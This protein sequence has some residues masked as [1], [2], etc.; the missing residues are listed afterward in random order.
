MQ[1]QR[2]ALLA[3]LQPGRVKQHVPLVPMR[4]RYPVHARTKASSV[5]AACS[6]VREQPLGAAL[7][8]PPKILTQL[9][10]LYPQIQP[11]RRRPNHLRLL[12]PR[13]LPDNVIIV[14]EHG[15]VVV[16]P[17]EGVGLPHH[18]QGLLDGGR[19]D[20]EVVLGRKAAG[21]E[22]AV[23]CL[24]LRDGDEVSLEGGLLC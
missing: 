9:R 20:H 24:D 17:G 11:R 21:V 1:R 14:G 16:P 6:R 13:R 3:H 2:Q 10:P 7:A 19:E 12:R 15:H 8:L 22:G 18:R 23:S 5:Q 4:L